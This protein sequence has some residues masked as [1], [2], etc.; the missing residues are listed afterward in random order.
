VTAVRERL[1]VVGN[2]MAATR[3]VEELV[4]RDPPYAITVIGDEP[5]PA[6]NRILL[7]AVLE[8]TYRPDDVWL[9]SSEWY[10]DRGVDVRL[11]RR[12]TYVDRR[13]RRV[14]LSDGTTVDYDRLVFATGSRPVLPPV[15]GLVD[16]YGALRPEVHAFRSYADCERLRQAAATARR[17]VVVGG[18]LLGLQVGRAL[19]VLGVDTEIVEVGPDL[20]GRQLGAAAARVLEREVRSRGTEVYTGAGA[21]RLTDGG[22]ILDNGYELTADLI[23]LTCGSR[24]ASRLAKRSALY[25]RRGI[26]V[27]DRLTSIT[28]DRVHAI[29]DCAEHRARVRGFVG[30][31]WE[32]ATALAETLCGEPT[33]YSGSRVVAR[34]RANGLDVAVLGEPETAAGEV[35]EVANPLAGTYRK[36]VIRDGIVTAGVLVGDLSRVGLITQHYDRATVLGPAEPGRLL[37]GDAAASPVADLPDTTQV[38]VCAGVTAGEIRRCRDLTDVAATTRATTGCGSCKGSVARLLEQMRMGSVPQPTT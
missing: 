31:A 25:V 32:Q 28:D 26:V 23:V 37:L 13:R 22:L 5:Q 11:G 8:G 34:L 1:V 6:Y 35:V 18:G 14:G 36:L 16:E 2:G 30:P 38:C 29:G 19:S 9:R 15:R 3:L 24:P 20:M 17:A 27:D 33:A 21:V 12:A 7:S 4:R 10:A